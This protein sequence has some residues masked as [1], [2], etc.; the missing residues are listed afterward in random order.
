MPMLLTGAAGDCHKYEKPP[1]GLAS[2][3]RNSLPPT[4]TRIFFI[5]IPQLTETKLMAF[6]PPPHMRRNKKFPA[7]EQTKKNMAFQP[8]PAD[9]NGL[10]QQTERQ[11]LCPG[12]VNNACGSGGGL[13]SL[14][15]LAWRWSSFSWPFSSLAGSGPF[16]PL[17][18]WSLCCSCHLQDSFTHGFCRRN[19]RSFFKDLWGSIP[20]ENEFD[21]F[22]FS[23]LGL[24]SPN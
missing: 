12:T 17:A 5:F 4:D 24:S 19:V 11:K 15:L 16:P 18:G 14:S 2:L 21:I 23:F 20:N 6:Q 10:P 1:Q 3:S 22:V 7:A 13:F 8:P 9:R